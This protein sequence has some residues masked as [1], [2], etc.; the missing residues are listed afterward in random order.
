MSRQWASRFSKFTPLLSQLGVLNNETIKLKRS[1]SEED[2]STLK[3]NSIL[4]KTAPTNGQNA[5]E[6]N[7]E[8]LLEQINASKSIY[9]ARL[10]K[11][12]ESI[13]QLESQVKSKSEQI[14]EHYKRLLIIYDNFKVIS[15]SSFYSQEL[16]DG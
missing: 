2:L 1:S 7:S 15:C 10:K 12:T 9:E 3:V 4:N 5:N 6:K 8:S 11:Q 13:E 16:F 14:N